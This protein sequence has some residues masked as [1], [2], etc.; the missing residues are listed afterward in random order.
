MRFLGA[1]ATVV[2]DHRARPTTRA[3]RQWEQQM[4]QMQTTRTREGKE[5][6]PPGRWRIDSSHSDV[7]FVARHMMISKVRGHFREVTGTI[8]VTDVPEDSSVEVTI[9]AASI[10][11]G[12]AGRDEHLRS[13]DFLDVAQHPEIRYRSTA[14]H[15]VGDDKW[16]VAGDLTIRDVTRT[17]ILMVEFCGVATDPWGNLRAGFVAHSEIDREAFAITWNQALESGGFLVGKGVKI[18][19]DIEAVRESD[20]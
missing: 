4:T 2:T 5:L 7:Q 8:V 11:T 9:K 10:D 20:A 19:L 15:A 12:D 16:Q 3:R 1:S 17:A 6:P 18:E 14:V 13:A